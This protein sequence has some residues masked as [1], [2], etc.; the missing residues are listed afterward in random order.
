MPVLQLCASKRFV[1]ATDYP[2]VCARWLSCDRW[3]HI[4]PGV[5]SRYI[6]GGWFQHLSSA[7]YSQHGAWPRRWKCYLQILY[8]PPITTTPRTLLETSIVIPPQTHHTPCPHCSGHS[9]PF[10]TNNASSSLSSIFPRIV[11]EIDQSWKV[12]NSIPI[13]PSRSQSTA[14]SKLP[15]MR[16]QLSPVLP[17]PP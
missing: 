11:C 17:S 5:G 3:S 16:M 13:T 2:A 1:N 10:V 8:I 12:N 9:F 6:S 15:H 14:P 4:L 7:A